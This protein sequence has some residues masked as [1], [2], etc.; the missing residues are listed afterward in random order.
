MLLSAHFASL[1]LASFVADVD[2]NDGN[3][4]VDGDYNG[5]RDGDGNCGRDCACD[6]D[7]YSAASTLTSR[8][9]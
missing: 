5:D 7:S 8:L 4:Q 9:A 2:Y 3:V 6:G 1:T